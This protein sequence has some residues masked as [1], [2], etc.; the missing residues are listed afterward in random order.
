[1]VAQVGTKESKGR[2]EKF[3]NTQGVILQCPILVL[4]R[5]IYRMFKERNYKK[6]NSTDVVLGMRLVEGNLSV[7]KLSWK[8]RLNT[9][10]IHY[11]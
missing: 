2:I 11:H 3:L 5:R 8:Q 7:A 6:I 10:P 9:Y 1:M 4:A